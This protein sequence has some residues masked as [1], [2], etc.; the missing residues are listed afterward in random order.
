[1]SR[2]ERAEGNELAQMTFRE[3]ATSYRGVSRRSLWR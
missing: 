3:F 2:P 1:V